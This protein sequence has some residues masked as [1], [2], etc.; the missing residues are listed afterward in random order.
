MH[1]L[2]DQV[3]PD[4]HAIPMGNYVIRVR[5]YVSASPSELGNYVSADTDCT[6]DISSSDNSNSPWLPRDTRIYSHNSCWELA[7]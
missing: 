1:L 6:C 2:D 5:N 7:D 3:H 4:T